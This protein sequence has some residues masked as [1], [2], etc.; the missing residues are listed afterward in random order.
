MTLFF[1]LVRLLAVTRYIQ[2]PKTLGRCVSSIVFSRR[3]LQRS[4]FAACLDSEHKDVAH[5]HF[6]SPRPAAIRLPTHALQP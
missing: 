2:S 1:F 3:E 6:I 4:H 5:H